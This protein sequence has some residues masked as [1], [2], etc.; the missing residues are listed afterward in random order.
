MRLENGQIYQPI[1]QPVIQYQ[2]FPNKPS[3]DAPGIAFLDAILLNIPL[4]PMN[5]N[6]IRSRNIAIEFD[7]KEEIK[8]LTFILDNG[9][10]MLNPMDSMSP[11]LRIQIRDLNN[12]RAPTK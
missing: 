1:F 9:R 2:E 10:Y 3:I 6:K 4:F 8:E 7:M 11:E 5:H 12:P